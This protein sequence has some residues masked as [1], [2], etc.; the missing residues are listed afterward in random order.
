MVKHIRPHKVFSN[1]KETHV[2]RI[3]QVFLPEKYTPKLIETAILVALSKIIDA[4]NF[5]EFGTYLGFQTLNIAMN[6]KESSSVWT[7][8]LDK[9]SF[10]NISQVK[11]DKPI[12]ERHFE[13]EDKL[14]FLDTPL[15]N[16]ISRLFGD[17]NMFDFSEFY[18]KVDFIYIDGGHD[19]KTLNSDTNNAL[20]MLCET[21]MSCI[22]WHDYGNPD[23]PGLTEFLDGLSVAYDIY[24]VED[25]MLCFYVFNPTTKI[26]SFDN[27]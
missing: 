21:K 17:S 12:S 6:M 8:D 11:P 2:E 14:A 20:K 23:F 15:E 25:T 1:V 4:D 22:A 24:H 13:F 5:F 19:T 3:I 26:I 9:E 7:L 18:G 27:V 10:L 16:R